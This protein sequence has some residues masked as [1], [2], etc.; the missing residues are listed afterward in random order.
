MKA[1]LL[2]VICIFGGAFMV[3]GYAIVFGNDKTYQ[4]LTHNK[5]KIRKK[6]FEFKYDFQ[7]L[8]SMIYSF[9]AGV[10]LLEPLKV[11]LFDLIY[12]AYSTLS[13]KLF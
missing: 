8:S 6:Q 10:L 7:W 3:W 5:L 2:C 9:F 12:L 11:L 1:W 4:V 13:H